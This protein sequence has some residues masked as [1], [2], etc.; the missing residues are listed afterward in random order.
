MIQLQCFLLAIN[1]WCKN[2]FIFTHIF[3]W[4]WLL[5]LWRCLGK[6]WFVCSMYVRHK[7]WKPRI[8]IHLQSQAQKAI[9]KKVKGYVTRN[10]NYVFNLLNISAFLHFL[11]LVSFLFNR[12][13]AA[14]LDLWT[15]SLLYLLSDQSKSYLKNKT[16]RLRGLD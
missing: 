3:L 13:A 15:K 9:Q 12:P 6:Q 1:E 10:G 16:S 7:T 14:D 8:H 5:F 4:F 2:L 11:Q